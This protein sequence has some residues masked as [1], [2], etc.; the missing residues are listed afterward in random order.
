MARKRMRLTGFAR[1]FLFLIIVI[2]ATYFGVTYYKGED[3]LQNLKDWFQSQANPA[4]E[5][6]TEIEDEA[7]LEEEIEKMRDELKA[8][9]D[10]LKEMEGEVEDLQETIKTQKEELS[11]YK[12]Q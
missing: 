4:T 9:K 3:G 11:N 5:V 7:D 1:F 12:E 2:P 6:P 8:Q 10:K